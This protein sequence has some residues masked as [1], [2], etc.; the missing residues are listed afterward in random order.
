MTTVKILTEINDYIETNDFCVLLKLKENLAQMKYDTEEY[1][2]LLDK[3]RD[4]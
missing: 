4:Y 2:E 3:I 1:R